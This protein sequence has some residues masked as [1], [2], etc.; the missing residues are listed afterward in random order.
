MFGCVNKCN[1]KLNVFTYE[2]NVPAKE[3]SLTTLFNLPA[4][5]NAGHSNRFMMSLGPT[6]QHARLHHNGDNSGEIIMAARPTPSPLARSH[7]SSSTKAKIF[8]KFSKANISG[9][10]G[11]TAVLLHVQLWRRHEPPVFAN[12]YLGKRYICSVVVTHFPQPKSTHLKKVLHLW[13]PSSHVI[14]L[15]CLWSKRVSD[16]RVGFEPYLKKAQV[17]MSKD[18]I[19]P[20]LQHRQSMY[21]VT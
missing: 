4:T 2:I 3:I 17:I 19:L 21:K 14:T 7:K 18:S 16:Q 1:Y 8:L 15:G 11:R 9:H 20:L 12:P 13:C 6:L 10:P 5:Q